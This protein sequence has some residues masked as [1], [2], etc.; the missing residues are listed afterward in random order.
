MDLIKH[1]FNIFAGLFKRFYS[2]S[3][4]TKIVGII[5]FMAFFL[6]IVTTVY[7]SK[8]FINRSYKQLKS[9]GMEIDKRLSA[10]TADSIISHHSKNKIKQLLD[11]TVK[12][13]PDVVYAMY[14]NNNGHST[15]L[16]FKNKYY[17]NLL[18]KMHKI[19]NKNINIHI[20]NAK[21]FRFNAGR[22]AIF[23]I[24]N[25]ITNLSG[26]RYG[27]IRIGIS[28][29]RTNNTILHIIESIVALHIII[30]A[31]LILISVVL[32]MLALSPIKDILKGLRFVKGGNYN[33]SVKASSD[34]KIN[35]LIQ[36]FNEMVVQ[37]KTLEEERCEKDA[38]RRN[39]AREIINIQESER[40]KVGRELHDE[41]GQFLAF[42]KIGFKFIYNQDDIKAIKKYI[43]KLGKDVD[44][45]IEMVR[46][47]AKSLRCAVLEELGLVKA[48]ELYINEIV[49]KHGLG[50]NFT[51][52]GFEE[53]RF[54]PYIETNIYRILQE[55]FLNVMRHSKASL[56][57]VILKYENGKITGIVEDDGTGFDYRENNNAN[58]GI[59]GMKE[60]VQLIGGTFNI[61]SE[62]GNGTMIIFNIDL[63]NTLAKG[64]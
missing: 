3:L 11:I 38:M 47:L 30:S 34:S 16:A 48:T 55:A 28:S 57:K 50:V 63:N 32:I 13:Y 36:A 58:M 51:A 44:K 59:Y 15:V 52:V 31:V 14:E 37:L 41:I 39:F 29:E 19:N 23:D 35:R 10:D 26:E 20:K 46:D 64:V 2:V 8:I 62:K 56:I 45:E 27:F 53:R 25:P 9:F 61:E 5:I 43:V 33:I 54:S 49:K 24:I 21:I 22:T 4:Q 7:I 18:N 42:L 1:I 12:S 60:R 6:S 40:K 17:F